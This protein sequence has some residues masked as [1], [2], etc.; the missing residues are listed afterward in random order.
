MGRV[1][2]RCTVWPASIAASSSSGVR[3]FMAESGIEGLEMSPSVRLKVFPSRILPGSPAVRTG[4]E[5]IHLMNAP[6]AA[7]A[8]SSTPVWNAASVGATN[9][10]ELDRLSYLMSAG[11]VRLCEALVP[12]MVQRG[13]G[14]VVV[15]SSIAAFTPMRKAGPY[16]AAKSAATAYARSLALEVRKKGVRVVAVCPGYVHTEL[17]HRAGLAHLTSKVPEWMWL[18]PIDVVHEA[19]R[20]LAR[21][22]S[23]VVPGVAYRLVRPFLASSLVQ[24]VWRRLTRR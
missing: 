24:S 17:H 3:G 14:E 10:D 8:V 2:S 7:S 4:C 22:K 6:S 20:A 18:E 16:A 12:P 19:R 1:W 9:R 13:H 15:V 11:V 21:G 23:V 5:E